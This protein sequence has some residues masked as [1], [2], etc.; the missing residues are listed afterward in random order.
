[1]ASELEST[2]LRQFC[3]VVDDLH[4]C[5]FI[6][7]AKVQDHTITIDRDPTKNRLPYYDRDEFRSFAT[8]FRKLLANREPTQ[9]YK[10]MKIIK[11][12]TPQK[13]HESFKRVKKD[14]NQLAINPPIAVAIGTTGNETPYTP[15][16]ICDALFNGLIFHTD[17]KLQDDVARILDYEPFVMAAFLQ[18]ATAVV[19]VSTQYAS[20]IEYNKFFREVEGSQAPQS[21]QQPASAKNG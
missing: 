7:R 2:I 15:Q 13:H 10:V 18:Y 19:N 3:K 4:D 11:R 5:R 14:L 6:K 9:I 12:Y 16:R 17:P 1:M 8:L 20:L 21:G